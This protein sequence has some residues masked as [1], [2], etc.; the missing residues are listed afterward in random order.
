[1]LLETVR[2]V[3]ELETSIVL[4]VLPCNAL[5]PSRSVVAVPPVYRSVPLPPWPMK[6]APVPNELALPLFESESVS[7]VPALITTL[8][9]NALELLFTISFPA[10]S[11]QNSAPP[12]EIAPV[13]VAVSLDATETNESP[14]LPRLMALL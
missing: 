2:F 1:M 6:M 5:A 10:P 3:A 7:N 8:C 12:D 4:D 14:L 9:V 13:S 11:F